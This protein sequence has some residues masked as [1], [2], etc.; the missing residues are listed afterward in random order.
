MIGRSYDSWADFKEYQEK[1]NWSPDG[2]MNS[3]WMELLS[4]AIESLLGILWS[5]EDSTIRRSTQR[6]KKNIRVIPC[7]Y[8]SHSQ[9][10][11]IQVY[12]FQTILFHRHTADSKN[13]RMMIKESIPIAQHTSRY[14]KT[15]KIGIFPPI[16]ISHPLCIESISPQ[17]T[18]MTH[19]LRNSP[20]P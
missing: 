20:L 6:A 17:S 10:Y 16:L 18:A 1:K 5:R 4:D 14:S 15:N 12:L 8:L 7:T 13:N 3:W 9:M 19:Q 11:F 2:A